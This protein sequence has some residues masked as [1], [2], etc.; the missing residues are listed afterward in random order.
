MYRYLSIRFDSKYSEYL[1]ASDVDDFLSGCT[2]LKKVGRLDYENSDNF[3]WVCLAIVFGD[4]YG[5]AQHSPNMI[6]KVNQIELI[7]SF[8]G[9]DEPFRPYQRLA[10]KISKRFGWEVYD[11]EIEG[12]CYPN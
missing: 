10:E 9:A 8:N 6:E 5:Y 4:E 1:T 7:C 3:P 12:V 2:E 11:S